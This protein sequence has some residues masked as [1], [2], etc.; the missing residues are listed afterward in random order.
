MNTNFL[1]VGSELL[2]LRWGLATYFEYEI[3]PK[4]NYITRLG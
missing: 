4:T 2:K 3:S 1:E